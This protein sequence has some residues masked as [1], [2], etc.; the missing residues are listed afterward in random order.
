[1][2]SRS[3]EQIGLIQP[4]VVRE[5]VGGYEVIAGMHRLTAFQQLGRAEIPAII[6]TDD[7]L[8]AELALIDENLIR[9]EF[10]P[11]ERALAQARRKVIYQILHPETRPG[12]A[13]GE[14]RK[15]SASGGQVGHESTPRYDQLAAEET[16]QSERTVRREVTRGEQLGDDVL[17]KVTGTSLDKGDELD[18]LAKL[19]PEKRDEVIEKVCAGDK[20]SAKVEAG[21][22]RRA[23]R[24]RQLGD[25]IAAMPE[26]KYGI[27]Y[28]DIPRHFNVRSDDTGLG[29][30][31]ENHFPTLSFDENC[32]LPVERLAAPDCILVYWSTAASLV[33][34]LDIM[35]EWGF[36]A[37]RPRTSSGKLVR[38]ADG[39]LGDVPKDGGRY[40][41]M[42]VWDKMKMGL[43]YWFRD[44]HEFILIGVRG[45]VVAPAPGTQEQSLFSQEKGEHSAKPERVAEMIERLW[46]STPKIE[47][48]RRGPPRKGW[49][50]WGNQV[51]APAP[52][53]DE[54]APG[55]ITEPPQ[56]I[57]DARPDH[58]AQS[59]SSA[60]TDVSPV[61]ACSQTS[62]AST[63]HGEPESVRAGASQDDDQLDIP[64]FLRRPEAEKRP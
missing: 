21:K 39:S 16:G 15:R 1:M 50:A 36:V 9:N 20:V 53:E 12:T 14:G 17:A 48:F 8:H 56:V 40:C 42:Q 64:A 25:A 33:D 29:R 5:V 19:S 34:D 55:E 43:G 4:I 59:D 60:R 41:S 10:S 13:Q 44:R 26:K 2:L 57:D 7:D 32:A 31:P 18:A 52:V 24:E 38:K 63:V 22:E 47:L 62:G 27:I 28:V 46:P 3:I 6:R 35:A 37:L 54:P 30:S 45:N 61:D 51:L 49:D 58:S 23:D 11:A